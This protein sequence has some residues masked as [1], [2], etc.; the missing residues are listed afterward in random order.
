MLKIFPNVIENINLQMKACRTSRRINTKNYMHKSIMAKPFT[1]RRGKKEMRRLIWRQE[2]ARVTYLDAFHK[3]QSTI[4]SPSEGKRNS[5]E[6]KR[7]K[8]SYI[9]R[10][11]NTISGWDFICIIG[12]S[13]YHNNIQNIETKLVN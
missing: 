6:C 2:H 10:R 4:P 5:E 11:I 13:R 7:G 9:H 12:D 3:A 1:G 8:K